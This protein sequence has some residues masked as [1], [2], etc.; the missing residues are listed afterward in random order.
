M[1]I[2]TINSG[3]ESIKFALYKTGNPFDRLLYGKVDRI[4][5]RG[6]SLDFNNLIENKKGN[7]RIE[8][9]DHKSV[10]IS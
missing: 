4:G 9:S 1:S 7:I 8:V 5:L 10:A 2:L 6:T 3:S